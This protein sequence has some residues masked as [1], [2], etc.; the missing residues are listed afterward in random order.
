MRIPGEKRVYAAKVDFDISTRFQD[1]I[2]QDLLEVDKSKIDKLTLL[3]YSIDER[4]GRIRNQGSLTVLQ[5]EGEWKI[6]DSS[7][8]VDSNKVDEVLTAVDELSIV[9]VRPKPQGLSEGLNRLDEE[10][11]RLTRQDQIDLQDKGYF[12]SVDGS[13]LSNEGELQVR[14][15]DGV[16][17]TLRFGEIVYGSGE[18]VSAGG[19]AEQDESQGPGENRYLFVTSEFLPDYFPEPPQP[20]NLDFQ[21]KEE[22]DWTA[23]DQ[24]NKRLHDEHERWKE[25]VEKGRQLSQ[26]LNSRFADWYY[27]IS[28]ENFR[29]IRVQR[30]DLI[31]DES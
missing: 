1:W 31:A 21:D 19:E 30:S 2:K 7:E 17:Y 12:F 4:S 14:T 10:G 15:S 22:S 23:A 27:V 9:G 16:L 13:L 8:E 18:T 6:E 11:L 20:S 3:D 29:K 28:D 26:E 5:E 24:E 25:K